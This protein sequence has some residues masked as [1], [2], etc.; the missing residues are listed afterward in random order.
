MGNFLLR[1]EKAKVASMDT[2][3]RILFKPF[4]VTITLLQVL[5]N[6]APTSTQLHPP[7]PSSF[8]P[9]PNSLQHPQQYLNQNWAI[10]PNLGRKSKSYPF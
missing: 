4:T 7:P 3:S 6:R 9:P 10:F 2:V 1:F 5:L 8:Q